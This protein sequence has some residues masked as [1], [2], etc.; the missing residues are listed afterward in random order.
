MY[1]NNVLVS[2]IYSKVNHI[3]PTGA[4]RT[5]N[6]TADRFQFIFLQLILVATMVRMSFLQPY[7]IS[8]L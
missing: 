5:G 6:T 3:L 4:K 8:L 1:L 7:A 2:L